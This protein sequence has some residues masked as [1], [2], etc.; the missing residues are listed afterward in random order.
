MPTWLV[1]LWIKHHYVD[2]DADG[3]ALPGD[4]RCLFGSVGRDVY[5]SSE[6]E[7]FEPST[8]RVA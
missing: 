6:T 1:E 8:E 2:T 5:R 3:H 4:E 7:K